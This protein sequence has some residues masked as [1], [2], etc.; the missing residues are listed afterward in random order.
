MT[1]DRRLRRLAAHVLCGTLFLQASLSWATQLPPEIPEPVTPR[2][3]V[4]ASRP[5]TAAAGEIALLP[6]WNLISLPAAPADPA[7]ASVFGPLGDQ[8]RRVW[9]YDACD[10]GDP[11]K[12]WDPSNPARSD[13]V[14]VSETRGLWLE[15]GQP[16]LLPAP[17][18]PPVSTVLHLCPGWNL[19][20]SP[21]AQA[22]P[23]ASVLAPIAGKYQRV[24]GYD[25]ADVADPWEIHDVAVPAWANDLK[26]LRPGRG[27]WILVIEETDLP[28]TNDGSELLVD[29]TSPRDGGVVTSPT[30][31]TGSVSGG[32]LAEW[33]L[34][35]RER[36]EAAWTA[37]G[38]GTNPVAGAPL[39]TLDPTALLNGMYEIRL[40]A[41]NGAGDAVSVSAFVNVEGGLKIG[42]LT[43]PFVD[44]EL[45]LV[46]LPIQ[47]VRT[48]DSRDKRPG[49]FGVGWRLTYSDVSLR[50][51]VEAGLHWRGESTGGPFPNYCIRSTAAHMVAVALP[52]GDVLRF[53]PVVTPECQKL[54]PQSAVTI[55]YQAQPGTR[56]TLVPLDQGSSGAVVGGFPG[57]LQIWDDATAELFNPS[58]FKLTLPDGREM[59]IVRDQGL[60][61]LRDRHGNAVTFSAGGITHSSGVGI[62][63]DRDGQGRVTRISDPAGYEVEY[64]YDGDNDLVRVSEPGDGGA[65]DTTFTYQADHYLDTITDPDGVKVLAAQYDGDRRLI[66]QCG[67]DPGSCLQLTHDRDQSREVR[68]DPT[69]RSQI[70][71]Y[72]L[73]GNV[74]SAANDLG[75]TSTFQYDAD[76]NLEK[77]TDPAGGMTRYTYDSAGNVTSRTE[78]HEVNENPAHFTTGYT[79]GAN[80]KLSAITYPTGYRFDFTY[81][82]QG[83]LTEIRDGAGRVQSLFTYD[84]TGTEVSES[85]PF[86]TVTYSNLTPYGEP[87]TIVGPLGETITADYN[88]AGRIT[89]MIEGDKTWTFTYDAQG[90]QTRADFGDGLAV[91]YSYGSGEDWLSVSSPTTGTIRRDFHPN[92][93]LKGWTLPGGRSTDYQYD[94]AGRPI[95]LQDAAGRKVEQAYD[96]AGRVETIKSPNGGITRFSYDAAGR[97]AAVTDALQNRQ[98]NEY[99]AGGRL[100]K[101]TNELGKSWSFTYGLQSVTETD[102]LARSTR[103]ELTADGLPAR[104]IFADGT[105][106]EWTYL[107][108]APASE[109]ESFP[110]SYR[111]EAGRVRSFSYNAFGQLAQAT[112][113]A[114]RA[115]TYTY[116]GALL[117]KATGATGEDIFTLDY[118]ARDN[119]R[120]LTYA[121]GAWAETTYGSNNRPS[122]V[123]RSSGLSVDSTYDAANRLVTQSSS[124]G[125][126]TS[127]TWT[128]DDQI[129]SVTN[130]SGTVSRQY[131]ASGNLAVETGA[132]GSRME[133]D[134]DLL[135]RVTVLRVR[136]SA[137]APVYETKYEY[138]AAGSIKKVIDPLG[139]VTTWEYDDV[140]RPVRRT[141]PNGVISTWGYDLRDRVESV[142]HR[143]GTGQ[144]LAAATYQRAASGEPTRVTREDGSYVVY[145]YDGALRLSG[146]GHHDATGTLIE[147]V[148]YSYD[149]AG[150]RTARSDASG[151]S[152]W[153][154]APGY[155]LTGVVGPAGAE[156]YG[157]DAD[158]RT[159]S[160]DRGGR[161]VRLAYDANDLVTAWRD[162]ESGVAI[163]YEND[164]LGRRVRS[165]RGAVSRRF[166]TV[167][168]LGDGL[169]SPHLVTGADGALQ[170]GFVHLPG[171]PLLRF[172]PDGPLYYLADAIG[173]VMALADGEGHQ[174]ARFTYDGFGVIRSASGAQATVPEALGGDYRFH[175]EWLEEGTGLYHLRARE[176]D[177]RTGRFLTK[178]PAAP[179]PY[180]V[181]STH[182]Y[183]FADSN[184]QIHGDPTGLFTIMEINI[185]GSLESNLQKIKTVALNHL[186]QRLKDQVQEAL[187]EI[188]VRQLQGLLP[189]DFGGALQFV[190]PLI[191]G[192]EDEE[193]FQA[194]KEFDKYTRGLVCELFGNYQHLLWFEPSLD[195]ESGKV[196]KRKNGYRCGESLRMSHLALGSKRPDLMI[197]Q[198]PPDNYREK[199]Y[200]TVEF[201]V[202]LT[203]FM[204]AY[205]L[206]GRN[207]RQWLAMSK[208]IARYQGAPIGVFVALRKKE[209]ERARLLRL[210]NEAGVDLVMITFD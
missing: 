143:D 137:S 59:V 182:P 108:T 126:V 208:H 189:L 84:T 58:R 207:K 141:L 17:G 72:D 102:S 57:D 188:L 151:A 187:T 160:I 169:D 136:A 35:I 93:R 153:S 56:G 152:A 155:R 5:L 156:T 22:R 53:A 52:G 185:T 198:A 32:S 80:G 140:N 118:D 110:A 163:T 68:T 115:T 167:P 144:V 15:A 1:D 112:D 78:P 29:I 105:D 165:V 3:R 134:R 25:P 148:T 172:G 96:A 36:G 204:R 202:T 54:V 90:R 100:R 197:R 183:V 28:I 86:G 47:V 51:T 44:M 48:Y 61:S 87:R 6:G 26:S 67:S 139:G 55:S 201:K 7:P 130:P 99:F 75:Q 158:G 190:E 40:Q 154:Y 161:A 171:G 49:D 122:S 33:R 63:I 149:A 60:E 20:G 16:S 106:Q 145:S 30:P 2:P 12:V 164:G 11:W 82:A 200:V 24:F 109:R 104:R 128:A 27:Y 195:P 174:A 94:L 179:E 14:E 46:G 45:K 159:A 37:I 31:V 21:V 73:R 191:A 70:Y 77:R 97:P 206:P 157:Y 127:Y 85:D 162:E 181:E 142:T 120:K 186:R 199:T 66:G 4:I 101:W 178:D 64:F 196:I 19:I 177:P 180:R 62:T 132:D 43:L 81:D 95:V 18:E 150:N 8:A 121:D 92:G 88:A 113:P 103:V 129:D 209:Y 175:G 135:G 38:S 42:H 9:S 107:G 83:N 117:R 166:V 111:D 125:D 79:Y 131:D 184:P 138:D 176:Y 23:V 203:A 133:L 71:T 119:V 50:E 74:T 193:W 34:E 39:G 91:Q 124:L 10:P 146:E 170:A 116:D 205:I 69:G 41:I 168:V 76:G 173:S 194:G 13:L 147:Q 89:T 192:A 114:G 65:R 123:Q 210:A 98:E